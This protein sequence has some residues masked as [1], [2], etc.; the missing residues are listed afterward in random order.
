MKV[1]IF[2]LGIL[3]V[4]HSNAQKIDCTSK[5][6]AY[7]EFLQAKKITES[8]DIWNDVR[9]NCPKETEAIY[10][11][12]IQIL[13]YK[14]D[15]ASQEEK[16]K[17]VRDIVKLYDQYNTNFPVAIPDFE[18][19]KAMAL[20]TNKIDSKE[21]IFSLLDSGFA[22][23][24]QNVTDAN[25][26]YTYFSMCCERFNDGDKK[27]TPNLVL[28]KYTSLNT[29]L[30]KLKGLQPENIEYKT[31]QRAIDELIKDI[32][33]CE[34]LADFYTKNYAENIENNDWITSALVSL[35]GNCAA[36]PIFQTLAE[37][38]YSIKVTQQSAYF[39]ALAN[40]KQRRFPEAIKFYNESAELQNNPTEKAKLF[41][42]LATGLLAND[43]P[44]SKEY[45]NKALVAD[46]KMG[47]AY[48]FLAQLYGNGSNDCGKTDFEKKA[49]YYLAIQ[50]AQ[51]AGIV[52]PRLKPTADKMVED[53][54]Q[55]T[56][57]PSEISKAKMNGKTITIGCW[58][59]ETI[60]FPVK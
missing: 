49:V 25:A 26:I 60:T 45:L 15:K 40:I 59:N 56:L 14:I 35:S 41:Y 2:L 47:K 55:K 17:S 28:A 53:F 36:K 7:Q 23:A 54:A 51:K 42:T 37:K 10:I 52:E 5:T 8:Y 33:T 9:K 24:S 19:K 30:N 18:I 11:D 12:G 50:T 48:L 34:N 32:A 13:Q 46:P 58:I 20:V 16:E 27:I 3:F 38:L 21:E 43:F 22:K 1:I 31:A 6:K 39:M 4:T 29:I 44:K 57:S